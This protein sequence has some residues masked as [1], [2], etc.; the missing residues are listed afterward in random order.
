MAVITIVGS[1]MMGSALAFPARENGHEVRLVGTHLDRE[2]IDACRKTDRHPK[3]TR[4]FPAGLKYF[5]IEELEEA[6][7]GSDLVIGGVSSFGVDW[8]GDYVLPK[9]ADGTNVLTVTKGLMDTPDGRLLPYP[10]LWQEKVDSLGKKIN[11]TAV[12][13]P[14]TSYELVAHDQT[15]VAFCG[16]DMEV[17]KQVKSLMQ[18]DYYHIS[19]STDIVGIE[20]AV[21]L[22]NGYA[23][24]IALTIGL[25]QKAFG[26]DSELH[27]NSQAAVFGQAAKEMYS[28][29]KLQG[30]ENMN[31]FWVGVGDLYVTVYGGRTRLVGI[32]LG[33]GLN[34]DE[35]REELNGVTLESLVVAVRV[36]RAMRIRAEKGDIDLKD[37]PLLMHVDDILTNKAEVNIPWEKFTFLQE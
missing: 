17:L 31:N 28:L 18:T 4:D 8:F 14:C 35:A 3:F 1:G 19:L 20:S 9:I 29:L 26:I 21:A 24:G 30:A 16:R 27:F 34:I 10:Y 22:K 15:E 23:L 5:Q 25:N 32:L 6:L 36:A 37:L 33:R 12:G 7:K 2:I 11:L 13:G